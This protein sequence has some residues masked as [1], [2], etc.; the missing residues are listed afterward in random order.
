MQKTKLL[1]IFGLV[2]FVLIIWS[3]GPEKMAALI[4]QADPVLIALSMSLLTVSVLVKAVRWKIIAA[5]HGFN[6]SIMESA[7]IWLIGLAGASVTPG[8]LGDFM[9]AVYVKQNGN[10]PLG[11]GISMVMV[12][13]IID[14]AALFSL[15][16]VGLIFTGSLFIGAGISLPTIV[17][18]IAAGFAGLW[19]LTRKNIVAFVAKPMFNHIVP[20]QY[21]DGL[22]GGFEELYKSMLVSL[23]QPKFLIS[24]VI[25]TYVSWFIA[26]FGTWL[27]AKA[28]GIDIPIIY[29][30]AFSPLA[31]LMELIPITVGGFG[32]REATSVFLY[33]LI[34]IAPS[35]IM[36]I[37]IIGLLTSWIAVGVGFMLWLKRPIELKGVLSG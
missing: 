32:T 10:L 2:L 3:A 21:R 12:E 16:G 22:K 13:R 14:V 24:V 27:T 6:C 20:K 1:A 31:T 5:N 36:S 29:I 4:L 8:R 25:L 28:F 26:F 11:R 33:G 35:V 19:A 37:I 30:A 17:I 23:K 18:V 15:A 9:K 34:D 7:R